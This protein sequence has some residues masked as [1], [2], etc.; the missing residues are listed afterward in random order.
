MTNS[1]EPSTAPEFHALGPLSSGYRLDL[2]LGLQEEPPEIPPPMSRGGEVLRLWSLVLSPREPGHGTQSALSPLLVGQAAKN[3][4]FARFLTGNL[5]QAQGGGLLD[6]PWGTELL[7]GA[8][9]GRL[10]H[11]GTSGPFALVPTTPQPASRG[12]PASPGR[13]N[14]RRPG[15]R[16]VSVIKA[17]RHPVL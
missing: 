15:L 14:A 4:C 17:T 10:Q 12:G 16:S 1:V 9:A 7:P 11:L 3:S 5:F 13:A 6:L 2:L 8:R